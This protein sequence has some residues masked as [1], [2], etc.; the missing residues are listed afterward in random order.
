MAVLRSQHSAQHPRPPRR[1]GDS[2]SSAA[3]RWFLKRPFGRPSRYVEST[4]D[5]LELAVTSG[6]DE[7]VDMMVVVVVDNLEW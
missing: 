4:E 7:A 2:S 1:R 3:S 5:T 6:L